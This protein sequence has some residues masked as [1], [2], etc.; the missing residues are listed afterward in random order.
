[1][2]DIGSN[3]IP[4]ISGQDFVLYG[5][6]ENSTLVFPLCGMV[7]IMMADANQAEHG[8][9]PIDTHPLFKMVE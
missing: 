6:I 2:C 7:D 8:I 4:I 5:P 3:I 1:M 9:T